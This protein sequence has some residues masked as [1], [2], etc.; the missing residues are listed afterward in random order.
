M[1][2]ER[3]TTIITVFSRVWS[4]TSFFVFQFFYVRDDNNDVAVTR[5]L[6][7]GIRRKNDGPSE[8]EKE[9]CVCAVL[10]LMELGGLIKRC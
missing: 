2:S 6:I 10:R 4:G 3:A 9:G 7:E 5:T 8:K 1:R